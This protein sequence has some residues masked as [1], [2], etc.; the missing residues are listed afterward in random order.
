MRATRGRGTRVAALF[1]RAP[2]SILS[3]VCARAS[4]AGRPHLSFVF[5]TRCAEKKKRTVR[6]RTHAPSRLH[7][8]TR[9][10]VV[11]SALGPGKVS[12]L[13]R[14][15]PA[16]AGSCPPPAAIDAPS[17]GAHAGPPPSPP[18]ARAAFLTLPP[19]S[20]SSA[21][22]GQPV[23]CCPAHAQ[24]PPP[25]CFGCVFFFYV[26]R[27][28]ANCGGTTAAR[29]LPSFPTP[30]GHPRPGRARGGDWAVFR[31]QR[32]VSVFVLREEAWRC[33]AF[34]GAFG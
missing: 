33:R 7:L 31:R 5:D 19:T 28:R 25:C 30:A 2:C 34:C 13:A 15:G 6:A 1:G 4:P 24:R 21:Y 16:T 26:C 18:A 22:T 3:S 9:G 29:S 27:A 14:V 32:A 10:C 17:A 23:R 8:L 12:P 11:F 20:S